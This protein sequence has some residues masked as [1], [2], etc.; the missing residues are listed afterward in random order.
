MER[1]SR[2]ARS[3]VVFYLWMAALPLVAL[4]SLCA[5]PGSDE[6]EGFAARDGAHELAKIVGAWRDAHGR[7]PSRDDLLRDGLRDYETLDVWGHPYAIACSGADVLIVSRG[8][9]GAFATE[10]D[11]SIA[12]NGSYRY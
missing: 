2:G 1:R 11:V 5:P 6:V 4:F 9:D 12:Q 8:R 7:C 10:D 3:R